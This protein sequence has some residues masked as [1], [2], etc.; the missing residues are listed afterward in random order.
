MVWLLTF[1]LY[2]FVCIGFELL[3]QSSLRREDS[4][5]R[6]IIVEWFSDLPTIML[7]LIQFVCL[8]S[9]GAIYR[10]LI[11]KQ[12]HL[13]FY[14]IAFILVVPIVL[15]NLV[16]AVIVNSAVEQAE[17]DKEARA[18]REEQIKKKTIHEV[19][20]I[21]AD[22]DKD[23]S[24]WEEND[25]GLSFIFGP[26]IVKKFSEK[27]DFDLIVRVHQVFED[28]YEF[29]APRQL[30]TLFSAPNYCAEFVNAAAIM[31]IDESLM[32][33]FKALKPTTKQR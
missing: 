8:D 21:W 14:F 12:F 33:S 18:F 24:S 6:F 31:S 26:D 27:F 32:C 1:I 9:V 15:M 16:T 10:P 17:Q 28:G 30:I 19:R 11:M 22:P 13:S 7:T 5:F 2:I 4:E 25:R 29:F 20:R 3:T 23:I